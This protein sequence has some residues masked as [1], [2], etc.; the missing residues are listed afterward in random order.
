MPGVKERAAPKPNTPAKQSSRDGSSGQSRDAVACPS[1]LRDMPPVD[2]GPQLAVPTARSYA[3]GASGSDGRNSNL[4]IPFLLRKC[5]CGNVPVAGGECAECEKKK[6]SLQRKLAIGATDDPL[7][8]EA[9]RV[10]DQVMADSHSAVSRATPR[11]QRYSGNA[12]GKTEAA[13]ASVDRVLASPGRPLDSALQQDMGQRF[14]KDFSRVRLHSGAAAERSAHDANA[15]AYTVGHD[16]VFGSGRFAPATREGQRLLAHELTHV[17]Q[18][19]GDVLRRAPDAKA[20]K[21]FDERAKKIREHPVFVKLKATGKRETAEIL[22]IIRKRDDALV[23]LK[24]LETLFD[25]PEADEKAQSAE[26]TFEIERAATQNVERLKRPK[27]S[28]HKEDEEGIS[29]DKTRKFS[30]AK[31]RDGSTFQIDARDVTNIALIVKVNLTA[32][33][34]TKENT[35]AIAKIK[36]LEDAIEKRIATW[37]YGLDLIFVDRGGPDVFTIDVNTGQ[38]ADAG[39]VAGGDATF[40]HELHHLLG[41]E[42]D[43][44]DY[45]RHAT[46]AAMPIPTRIYWFRQEFKKVIDNNPESIMNTDEK[47]PLDDDVCMVAGKRTKAA[48]DAC[49][50]QRSEARNKIINPAIAQAADWAKKANERVASDAFLTS[51]FEVARIVEGIFDNK[52]PITRARHTLAAADTQMAGLTPVNFRLVSALV[53]GCEDDAAIT[54]ATILPLE[55]CPEFFQMNTPNQSWALLRGA[56]H[57]TGVGGAGKDHECPTDSC[58]KSCGGQESAETW[59]RLTRCIAEA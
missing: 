5:P 23:Q 2:D 34:K 45:T 24:K 32:K 36:T 9:D 51:G 55:L 13:P 14:G 41:L 1:F 19:T 7:E 43:R 44:Y 8:L 28:V 56:L 37:G 25:T 30:K 48:I 57:L 12:S 27:E 26:T 22:A 11:I 16:I 59:A 40:A 39:N 6:A 52:F 49:V 54:P 17:V 47:S 29:K 50:K 3:S 21:E 46:N 20:L 38:W 31:G 35:E 42:E 18:Q 15:H 58:T 10:A 33:T 53:P 4:K